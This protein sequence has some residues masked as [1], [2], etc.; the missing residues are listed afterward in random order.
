MGLYLELWWMEYD[1]SCSLNIC[2]ANYCPCMLQGFSVENETVHSIYLIF[3]L[4]N[5]CTW[6]QSIGK[7]L[8]YEFRDSLGVQ[9]NLV[10]QDMHVTALTEHGMS[11][12]SFCH[13]KYSFVMLEFTVFSMYLAVI[14]AWY[15]WVFS[16]WYFMEHW[17][18]AKKKMCSS[19]KLHCS[20]KW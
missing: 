18:S 9:Y 16:K 3:F 8:P 1:I 4:G 6:S 14:F 19:S 20:I 10:I 15:K 11:S 5:G 7:P 2:C 17:F 13:N 12:L